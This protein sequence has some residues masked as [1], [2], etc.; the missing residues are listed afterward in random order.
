MRYIKLSSVIRKVNDELKE[1]C[2]KYKF[3]YISN[4]EIEGRSF[5]R[6]DFHL[7]DNGMNVLVG[8]FVNQ[9]TQVRDIYER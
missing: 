6:D 7:S 3:D 1:L 2:K 8:G 5:L 9:E 4:D